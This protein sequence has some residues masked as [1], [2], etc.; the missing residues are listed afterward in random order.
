MTQGAAPEGFVPF[1]ARGPF[2]SHIGPFAHAPG[3]D[4]PTHGFVVQA[5]HCNTRRI[6]HGG[7][8]LAFMD[9][10]LA[11]AA[12]TAD[13]RGGVTAHLSGDFLDMARAGDWVTGEAWLVAVD[14][15]LVHV[16]GAA[17]VGER[18]IWRGG[19]IFK[20][21]GRRRSPTPAGDAPT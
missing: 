15:D 2:S 18:P 1:A 14:Q 13:G 19:A 20:L 21:M 5:H 10:V 8:I 17:K 7:M 16:E 6:L 12:A 4:R 11:H 3:A 9:G